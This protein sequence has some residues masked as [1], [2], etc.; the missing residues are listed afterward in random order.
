MQQN[1]EGIQGYLNK[2][3]PIVPVVT[4]LP[5]SPADGTVIDYVADSTNGV[6]WRFRYRSSSGSSYK[7]EFVGGGPLYTSVGSGGGPASIT[8]ATWSDSPTTQCDVTL[9]LAGDYE[10]VGQTILNPAVAGIAIV[11]VAIGVGGSPG[12]TLQAVN[13]VTAGGY[14]S[15]AINGLSTGL[16]GGT[17]LR[18]RYWHS[19][20]GNI[21]VSGT[22]LLTRPIRVG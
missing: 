9:P 16:A 22:N 17:V 4:A 21:T 20:T 18:M 19:S 12:V 8:A 7:W 10:I 5:T 2:L 3:A 1:F 14:W 15:G 13:Y 11:G 6:V